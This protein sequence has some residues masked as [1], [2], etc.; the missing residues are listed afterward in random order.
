MAFEHDM[1]AEGANRSNPLV[2]NISH[3]PLQANFL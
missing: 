1:V 3:L 2:A